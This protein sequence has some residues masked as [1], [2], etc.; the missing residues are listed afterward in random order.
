MRRS[1]LVK[2]DAKQTL[3]ALAKAAETDDTFAKPEIVK[4][5]DTLRALGK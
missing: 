5:V 4:A 3:P 1:S 2:L